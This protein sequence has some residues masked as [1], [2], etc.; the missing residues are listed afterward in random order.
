MK[1][2]LLVTIGLM[3]VYIL[4]CVLGPSSVGI[5]Q[6]K[7]ISA[8]APLVFEQINSF[9]NWNNWSPWY[10]LDTT[11]VYTYKG[12]AGE[13]S[14]ASWVS[15][16]VNVG[17]GTEKIV[18]SEPNKYVEIL[19]SFEGQGNAIAYFNL[20]STNDST[21]ETTW[22]FKMETPF[23]ARAIFLLLNVEEDMQQ[24]IGGSY[25]EGL[26]NLDNFLRQKEI[27]DNIEAERVR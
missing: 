22:G 23:L 10:K 14:S 15:D 13:G 4:L 24:N 7:K 12:D 21:T 26:Q 19:L 11:A 3:A 5:E 27:E 17:N 25:K 9:K 18:K 6:T 16:S 20:E 1:K 8:P 2:V